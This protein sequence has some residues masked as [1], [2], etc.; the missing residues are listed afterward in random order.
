MVNVL[1]NK[2]KKLL[3]KLIIAVGS[4]SF[5]F[6]F[7]FFMLIRTGERI[8]VPLIFLVFIYLVVI[9]SMKFRV[10][11]S[12]VAEYNSALF[13]DISGKFESVK[14]IRNP[15]NMEFKLKPN[16]GKIYLNDNFSGIYNGVEFSFCDAR[17]ELGVSSF[18]GKVFKAGFNKRF[19]SDIFIS[20]LDVLESENLAKFE[21]DNAYINENFTL[22]ADDIQEAMYIL[23]PSLLEKFEMLCKDRD[24]KSIRADILFSDSTLYIAL[25]TKKDALE[26]NLFKP[27]LVK[28]ASEL[29]FELERYFELIEYLNL[30]SK[31]FKA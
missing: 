9:Y 5:V 4:F 19:S 12:F 8:V 11:N 27:I 23:T 30:D 1:E 2:R 28:D 13:S 25:D 22:Y 15:K 16:L 26:P 21:I 10:I 14:Y 24:G 3:Q 17:I 29:K 20:N 31:F 7:G 6:I 18:K